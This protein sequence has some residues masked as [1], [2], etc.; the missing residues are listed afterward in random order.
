MNTQ[1]CDGW[2]DRKTPPTDFNV[3]K[4]TVKAVPSMN[5]VS[6]THAHI[7]GVSM[8]GDENGTHMIPLPPDPSG[9]QYP[10]HSTVNINYSSSGQFLEDPDLVLSNNQVIPVL[11]QYQ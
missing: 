3:D 11:L 8:T 7:N 6:D 5:L 1:L 2:I 10:V 4:K 9:T